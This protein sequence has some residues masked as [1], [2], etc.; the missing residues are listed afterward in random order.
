MQGVLKKSFAVVFQMLLY[1][2]RTPRAIS[3][4]KFKEKKMFPPFG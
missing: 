4:A 3:E 1:A 2:K